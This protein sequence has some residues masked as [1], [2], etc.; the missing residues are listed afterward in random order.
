MAD[1]SNLAHEIIEKVGGRDNVAQVTHCMTR[2]RFNVKDDSKVDIEAIKALKGVIGYVNNGGQHQIIIGQ[3]VDD[4]YKAVCDEGGFQV[5]AAVDEKLDET[6]EKLSVKG[7]FNNILNYL[8]GSLTPLIPLIISAAMFRTIQTVLG[9][10]M[11]KVLSTDS[12]LYTILGMVYNA[13]FYFLPIYLGYTSAKKLNANPALGMFMGGILIAPELLE[14]VNNG[15]S[16]VRVFGIP[17]PVAKYTQT[18][19]PILLSVWVLSIVEKFF[20]RIIPATLRTIFSPFITM[21]ILVP[22]SLCFLAPLG[23]WVGTGV[24]NILVTIGNKGGFLGVAVIAALWE[25]LVMGGMHLVLIFSMIGVLM[26]TGSE[27]I[28]APASTCA[29]F[30]VMGMALGAALRIKDKDEKA[31][32]FGYFVSCFLGG[33]TEPA[34]YGTGFKY[35]KPFIGMIIGAFLGGLYAGL[36]HI[37]VYMLGA[38]NF[39]IVLG[40]IGGGTANLV[41]GIIACVISLI[42]AAAATY[43]IGVDEKG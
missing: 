27:S 36:T 19:I 10:D 41:N 20:N 5:M 23:N 43:L 4:V 9:P 35:K 25:F 17:A 29:T 30:A 13:G 33:V 32:N 26:T 21:L 39:L 37:A 34:L 31:L 40:F 11:L 6:K 1:Y 18:I 15:V 24:G 38:T 7:I 3:T 8:S 16:S 2:L 28:I 42:A 12:D 22:V 14:M